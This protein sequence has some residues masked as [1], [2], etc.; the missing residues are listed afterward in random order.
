MVLLLQ[1]RKRKLGIINTDSRM[2]GYIAIEKVSSIIH[3]YATED[4]A[5]EDMSREFTE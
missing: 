5:V 4:E 1:K 2:D 3:K